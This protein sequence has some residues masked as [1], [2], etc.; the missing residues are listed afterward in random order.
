MNKIVIEIAV[1][2]LAAAVGTAG[3]SMI[4]NVGRRV[5]A[6]AIIGAVLSCLA[7]EVVDLFIENLF[8]VSM[9][10]SAVAAI[11]SEIMAHLLKIP[12]T[13]TLIPAIVPLVPGR[14][15]YYTMFGIVSGNGVSASE[16]AKRALFTSLGIALGIILVT[17]VTRA[18]FPG[19]IS[20]GI[21]TKQ[22]KNTGSK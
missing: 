12:A 3:I 22:R 8:I 11:Y 15:L 20:M 21:D 7:Y 6:Y 17:L 1:S 9:I 14:M 13:V 18:I 10:A 5:F 4:Y 2:V 19:I 16:N